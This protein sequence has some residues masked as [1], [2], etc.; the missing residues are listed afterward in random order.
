MMMMRHANTILGETRLATFNTSK[1]PA[2]EDSSIG[3]KTPLG[4]VPIPAGR[5]M[6]HEDYFLSDLIVCYS[7]KVSTV[8]AVENG[9]WTF[10]AFL[11]TRSFRCRSQVATELPFLI[12]P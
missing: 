11:E 6:G 12:R 7:V 4:D 1:A 2:G 9:C 3:R 5:K 8:H 10:C